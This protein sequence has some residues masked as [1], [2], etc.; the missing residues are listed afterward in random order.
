MTD[1]RA[2]VAPTDSASWRPL[3]ARYQRP[4][5]R[6]AVW[7]IATTLLPLA[8]LFA[9]TYRLLAHSFWWALVFAMPAAA[10]LVRTFVLMHDCAHGSFFASRRANRIVGVVTGLL[11]LMPFEHWRHEHGLHHASAGD[12]DRRGHGD[13]ETLTVREYLRRTPWGR[14]RYRIIRH[15]L[16]F[17]VLGPL[18][19]VLDKRLPPRGAS[20]GRRQI[21]SVWTTNTAIVIAGGGLIALF[22]ARVLLIY[23]PAY[24]IAVAAGLWLFFVQHQFEGTYWEDH[25]R[26]DYADAAIAGSSYFRL[27]SVLRWVT[28]S[29]GFH[30]VHHLG[31]RIPNYNLRRC[32]DENPIFH[33][34]TVVTLRES[35]SALRLALWDE[36]AGQL[37]RFDRALRPPSSL[38]SA[39]LHSAL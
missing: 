30:H 5:T 38:P 10:L 29:I 20:A 17:L 6:R 8:I 31:P 4:R 39:P 36:D 28:G 37:V 22:G 25:Q 9:T 24:Y 35:L 33:R 14:L 15:P 19:F 2:P 26:W 34:A 7:Q 11:T 23:L 21:A 12:L 16:V 13:V 3:V 1:V 18:F 32:H 27:P